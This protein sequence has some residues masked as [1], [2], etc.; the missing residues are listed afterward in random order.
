MVLVAHS[1][2]NI[3]CD[4]GEKFRTGGRG[5]EGLKMCFFRT[6]FIRGNNINSDLMMEADTP[7]FGNL[8]HLTCEPVAIS[9]C[10]YNLKA[11]CS[12]YTTNRMV[13]CWPQE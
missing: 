9:L 4:L 13:Q 12:E 6:V 1:N 2:E 8:T 7:N 11:C 5:E 3:I 10:V